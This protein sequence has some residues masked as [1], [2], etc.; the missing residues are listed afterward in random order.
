MLQGQYSPGTFFEMAD[1]YIL[2]TSTLTIYLPEFRINHLK[3]VC[4]DNVM[5]W[6][7]FRITSPLRSIPWQTLVLLGCGISVD[8]LFIKQWSCLWFDTPWRL[9]DVIV[10][11]QIYGNYVYLGCWIKNQA[12]LDSC[13]WSVIIL[14][15]IITIL[16]V[17]E[18]SRQSKFVM[19]I[20]MHSHRLPLSREWRCRWSSADRR[21]SKYMESSIISLPAVN[22][23]PNP[24]KRHPI[25]RP[26]GRGMGC[27][28]R[29]QPLVKFC[30]VAAVLY[31][32]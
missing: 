17:L 20:L 4:H 21:C 23:H 12:Q 27:L 14:I 19:T 32:I 6:K 5:T 24:H 2:Q 18:M 31:T 26:S 15:T 10:M 8:R 25:A 11:S 22:F 30:P 1:P 3:C 28:L 13:W 29:V 9:C 16:I 7:R